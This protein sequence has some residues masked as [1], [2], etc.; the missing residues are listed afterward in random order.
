MTVLVLLTCYA[1]HGLRRG[2]GIA[3]LAAY[4]AFVAT[5]VVIA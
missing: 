4:G 1:N 3:I 5:L 2:A